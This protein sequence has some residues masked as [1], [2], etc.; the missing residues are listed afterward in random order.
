M[1]GQEVQT[2]REPSSKQEGTP[3][4]SDEHGPAD[5]MPFAPEYLPKLQGKLKAKIYLY[6]GISE[7][8]R[9][10]IRLPPLVAEPPQES[11]E[12]VVPPSGDIPTSQT[13]EE[14]RPSEPP[15]RPLRSEEMP[16]LPPSDEETAPQTQSLSADLPTLPLPLPTE[17]P[18]SPPPAKLSPLLLTLQF[19]SPKSRPGILFPTRSRPQK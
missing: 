3:S 15:L 10:A 11:L 6:R 19:D 4:S 9:Q 17:I 2:P 16:R 14:R 18:E 5:P 7:R 8:L 13:L 1:G 12:S